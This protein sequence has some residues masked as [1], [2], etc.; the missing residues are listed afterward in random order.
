MTD[1]QEKIKSL[2]NN[3]GEKE[4]F[5]N[6]TNGKIIEIKEQLKDEINNKEI[7]LEQQKLF[8]QTNLFLSQIL[9]NVQSTYEDT[10][11]NIGSSMLSKIFGENKVL[12]FKFNDKQEKNPSVSI[13]ISQPFGDEDIL[14]DIEYAEGG[15]IKDVV[16]LALRLGMIEIY[17]PKQDG[18]LVLDEP[19]RYMAKNESLLAA[20]DFLKSFSD[21]TQRQIL[22]VTHR[23]ELQVY[24]DRVFNL[25]LD[26][27]KRVVVDQIEDND[28]KG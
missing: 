4:H 10:F 23:P 8:E 13:M 25:E 26:K 18:M 11:G 21:E 15:G 17:T 27:D 1:I 19:F 5:I 9:S 24:A 3:I 22:L 12:R 2:K 6:I 14:T 28:G 20:G 7:D 16:A